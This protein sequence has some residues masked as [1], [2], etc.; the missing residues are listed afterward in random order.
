MTEAAERRKKEI[1]AD[2][3]KDLKQLEE[4]FGRFSDSTAAIRE[5]RD[6]RG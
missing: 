2:L 1:A 4:K 5:D 6:R 3:R